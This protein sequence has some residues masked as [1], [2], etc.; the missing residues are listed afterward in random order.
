[1]ASWLGNPVAERELEN[2]LKPNSAALLRVGAPRQR[3]TGDFECRYELR[4]F[5]KARRSKVYG[6]DSLQALEL[7][8]VAARAE[9]ARMGT[10]ATWMGRPAYLGLPVMAGAHLPRRFVDRI[11]R[12]VE[13]V[14]ASFYK[15]AKKRA[16]NS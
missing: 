2:P 11:E 5:G 3:R 8:I 13:R 7:A 4:G 16:G 12:A 6:V 14:L 9:L 15:E 10:G 1:M